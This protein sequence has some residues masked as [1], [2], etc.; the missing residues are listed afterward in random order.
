MIAA[1]EW[2]VPS[3][4]AVAAWKKLSAPQQDALYREIRKVVEYQIDK[5]KSEG[6]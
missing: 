4:M 3:R 6:L 2:R 5:W 1:L